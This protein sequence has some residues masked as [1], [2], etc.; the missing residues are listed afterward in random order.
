MQFFITADT[1]LCAG[2]AVRLDHMEL[3]TGIHAADCMDD[4]DRVLDRAG[5]RLA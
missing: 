1:Y 4:M 2:Q 5:N 3:V